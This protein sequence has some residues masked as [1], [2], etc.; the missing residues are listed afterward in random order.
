M[1]DCVIAYIGIGANL[2]DARASVALAI[3]R[4]AQLPAS[5]PLRHSSL[6]R[7]APFEADGGDYINAV[8]AITTTLAP[9][10]LLAELQ[11]IEQAFGRERPYFHAPRTLDLDLLLYGGQRIATPLLTV[12]HPG[13]TLRA[14]VLLPLLEIAPDLAIPA[15]GPARGFAAKVGDQRIE[16][17]P[18]APE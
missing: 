12:P 1:E 15:L 14:F 16:R 7:S 18:S 3:E 17:L 10:Q 6:Y 13:L 8:A 4:L 11:A 9:L 5:R 2:G